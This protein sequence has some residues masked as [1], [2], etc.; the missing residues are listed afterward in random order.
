VAKPLAVRFWAKVEKSDGC[1]LWTGA[2]NGH[3]YGQI[4]HRQAHRVAWEL[5]DGPPV[6]D[7]WDLCHHCD[8]RLCVNPAH[9]FPGTRADNMQDA[10]RKGRM[11][12]A[13]GDLNGRRTHP[14]RTARGDRSGSRTRPDRRPRGVAVKLAKLDDG[15]ADEIRRLYAAGGWS[16]RLLGLR[17]GVTKGTIGALMTGVTW[18]Q[19]S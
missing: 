19:P 7:G 1:W 17:F 5:A 16:Y 4:D 11:F 9:L 3:G 6:P 18:Q 12:K 8:V 14:E 2:T 15:R 13:T 10:V